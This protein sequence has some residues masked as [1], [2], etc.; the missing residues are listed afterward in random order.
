M[1]LAASNI[2]W[3]GQEDGRMLRCMAEL[4]YEGLEIAPTRLFPEGP[5]EKLQEARDFSRRLLQEYG[6]Q[7]CS[8][9]SIWYGQSLRIA[10]SEENR[11]F[12]LDYTAKAARFAREMGCDNLVFGCPR[13]RN[14]ESPEEAPI[15]EDFLWRCAEATGQFAVVLAL[16]ANPPIYHTNYLNTTTQALTLVKQLDHPFLR[17]NLDL[18]TVIENGESLDWL[19]RELPLVHHVH[20]SEPMLRPLQPR[21]QREELLEKLRRLGYRGFVSAEMGNAA[22]PTAAEKA[23]RELAASAGKRAEAYDL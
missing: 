2:G 14:L 20:I 7:A 19:E 18:G 9:Q 1:K 5:Y 10:E 15:L 23:L 3:T 6:L 8:L 12:L 13:N 4:G 21:A 22:G 11:R 16:E 17:L